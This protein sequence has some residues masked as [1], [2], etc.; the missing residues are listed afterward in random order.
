[1]KLLNIYLF[2]YIYLIQASCFKDNDCINGDCI[3]GNCYCIKGWIGKRCEQAKC[4]WGYEYK[5][6]C[7]C[8]HF[9]RFQNGYC[10]KNCL[11]GNFSLKEN[12]CN[13]Y[14]HWQKPLFFDTINWFKGYCSQFKC[15]SDKQCRFLLPNVTSPRC[16][17]KDTNCYCPKQIGYSNKHAKCMELKQWLSVSIGVYYY[18]IIKEY[19]MPIFSLLMIISLP[20][21]EK[22]YRCKC[23]KSILNKICFNKC[24]GNCLKEKKCNLYYEFSLT[25]YWLKSFIWWFVFLSL[26]SLLSIGF[27]VISLWLIVLFF[28]ICVCILYNSNSCENCNYNIILEENSQLIQQLNQVDRDN[29]EN[30]LG[31]MYV[32][33]HCSTYIIK[34]L[35]TYPYFPAN[36]EGGLVGF[37]LKTHS[38]NAILK[39]TTAKYIL[40]LDW[41]KIDYDLRNDSAWQAIN[42]RWMLENY[43]SFS[44]S[45]ICHVKSNIDLSINSSLLDE[46]T[47]CE[48]L[49]N[50]V[51]LRFYEC[52]LSKHQQCYN[53]RN[54]IQDDECWICYNQPRKWHKW[55]CN[56]VFCEK[57][58]LTLLRSG[59][60][61]PLCRKQP[62]YVDSYPIEHLSCRE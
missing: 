13:C 59:I 61:C 15:T 44:I 22:R 36:L 38:R 52:N 17:I 40:S 57:C 45:N 1:M 50:N 23:N 42:N 18:K 31:Y 56:H 49:E 20:F 48:T 30:Y 16:I 9:Y 54:F 26:I 53:N 46:D 8:N 4:V 60:I 25:F 28:M 14:Q 29:S 10:V 11:N 34:L 37:I 7:T 27:L 33:N 2:S 51:L 21:G 5:N 6:S 47:F 19:L 55:Q 39:P 58:S 62:D 3:N 24:N 41:L 43:Q 35:E 32:K 12:K